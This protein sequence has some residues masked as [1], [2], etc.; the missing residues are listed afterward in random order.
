MFL[1]KSQKLILINYIYNFV[2][3]NIFNR[4]EI[5]LIQNKDLRNHLI[6][7]IVILTYEES[8]KKDNL[9]IYYS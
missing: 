3:N 4:E 1:N 7:I 2:H 9:S 5:K 8:L 6:L